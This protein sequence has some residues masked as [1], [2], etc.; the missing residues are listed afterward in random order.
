MP[1]RAASET[2]SSYSAAISSS[3]MDFSTTAAT[4]PCLE[5]LEALA[6]CP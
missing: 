1:L 6:A 3:K 5:V 2:V 4:P